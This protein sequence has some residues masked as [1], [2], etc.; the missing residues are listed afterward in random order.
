MILFALASSDIAPLQTHSA[1]TLCFAKT[2]KRLA[3]NRFEETWNSYFN[4][5]PSAMAST[6]NVSGDDTPPMSSN[7]AIWLQNASQAARMANHRQI[8]V[9]DLI[10]ALWGLKH[11][12]WLSRLKTMAV[13]IHALQSYYEQDLLSLHIPEVPLRN[14]QQNNIRQYLQHDRASHLDQLGFKQYAISIAAFLTSSDTHGPIS[15]SIQAPWGVG[16][17][18]LMRQIQ[19]E[20]D[21]P[22]QQTSILEDI[23]TLDVVK[24]L[25][26]QIPLT[27]QSSSGPDKRWTVWFNAWKYGSSEEVWAGLVDAI[28]SQVS[29]RLGRVQRELFLLRLNLSRIDDGL[30][31]QKIYQRVAA[32]WWV[33]I[34]RWVLTA[35]ALILSFG[36]ITVLTHAVPD[37]KHLSLAAMFGAAGTQIA[38]AAY[39]VWTFFQSR[40]KVADE[41]AKFSLAE[42]VRVPDYAKS[43]GVMHQ[44]HQDLRRVLDILPKRMMQDGSGASVTEPL[45]IFIDDLDRCTPNKIASVVEGL[46]A[47]L[48]GD[49]SEFLFVIGMDPQ[50]VAAA[51]EHAH[52]DVKSHLPSYEQVVP[53]G[54][55]FMDKFIQ[56]GFT[57]PPVHTTENDIFIDFLIGP[58]T[59][60]TQNTPATSEHSAPLSDAGASAAAQVERSVADKQE[61]ARVLERQQRQESMALRSDGKDVQT[62]MRG[63]CKEYNCSPREIKRTLNFVRFL[64]LLR[65]SRT[66]HHLPIPTLLQYQRWSVLCMR[67]PDLALWLQWGSTLPLQTSMPPIFGSVA[68]QRLYWLEQC[69]ADTQSNVDEW[70]KTAADKLGLPVGKVSWLNNSE[71]HLF[72][73]QE[74]RQPAEHRISAGAAIG[75]Y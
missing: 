7:A 57:I 48:A 49:Q 51:L 37:L 1:E 23:R 75:F 9:G 38:L 70:G 64:L 59:S 26:R 14:L 74:T 20:L 71:V 68:A 22:A 18:S 27:Q 6:E 2:L 66:T 25:D 30:V 43:V 5:P 52:K 62:I 3:E 8:E 12:R 46:N 73:V 16:K 31:R 72:F 32:L 41:P 44:I 55:R 21:P 39:A 65:I 56:L 28:V 11:G 58:E 15:I 4:F 40:K 53:L 47:F 10:S 45:V 69:S 60:E 54:W 34:R 67:W 36:S 24:F 61:N 63:I 33:T 13:D 42:Y 50:V 29:E 19:Y 17:S 35:M